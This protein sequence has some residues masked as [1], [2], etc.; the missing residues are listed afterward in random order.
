[1]CFSV[2]IRTFG[3]ALSYHK[4]HSITSG[5]LDAKVSQALLKQPQAECSS[6]HDERQREAKDDKSGGLK[7]I[8]AGIGVEAF[9][10][11]DLHRIISIK[12]QAVT[13]SNL[14]NLNFHY[15]PDCLSG[16]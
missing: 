6:E 16:V 13:A 1:M 12:K 15:M 4:T 2:Q 14:F 10:I 5:L 9:V 11:I 7:T 8:G 3:Q